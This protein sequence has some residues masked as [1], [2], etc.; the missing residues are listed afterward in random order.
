MSETKNIDALSQ[1]GI[2][3]RIS[4]NTRGPV[5]SG[6][7]GDLIVQP[8]HDGKSYAL[9]DEGSEF[10]SQHPTIDAATTV[11]GHAAPVLADLYTKAFLQIRN[12]DAVT[13]RKRI[14]LNWI[15]ITVITP[16]ANGTSDNWAAECDTGADLYSSGTAPALLTVNPNMQSTATPVAA[17]RAGAITKSAATVNQRKM[18]SGVFRPVIAIAGD[19]YLFTF[20]QNPA[21][22]GAAVATAHSKAI[23]PMPAVELG[24]TDQFFLH[25]YAPSQSA[26]GVYKVQVSHFER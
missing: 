15:L 9:A 8:L 10:Y 11:A 23:V 13:S 19:Q 7:Y 24:P 12:T 18:G 4:P 17:L 26:A 5:R 6:E 22:L 25:L 20:G 16:G 3:S 21:T 14:Y 2:P 1:R